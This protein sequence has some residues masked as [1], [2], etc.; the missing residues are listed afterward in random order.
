[1]KSLITVIIFSVLTSKIENVIAYSRCTVRRKI[2][3]ILSAESPSNYKDTSI[4]VKAIVGGL[5]SIANAIWGE[6]NKLSKRVNSKSTIA[7]NDILNGVVGDFE[8]GYLFSGAIDAELYD[9]DCSFTDPTISFTGLST[10]ERNIASL[11]PVL[12]SFVGSSVV[13]LYNCSLTDS[14]V[15][16]RWRMSG[17][18]K[19]PWNPRIELTGSTRLTF[20][21]TK[22]GRIVSYFETWD[23]PAS[24]ALFQLLQP[25]IPI[26]FEFD[27]NI[28]NAAVKTGPTVALNVASLKMFLSDSSF[29][30]G[31]NNSEF[32]NALRLLEISSSIS[33]IDNVGG[34]EDVASRVTSLLLGKIWRRRLGQQSPS[35][36][37]TSTESQED[38]QPP[39]IFTREQSCT[40]KYFIESVLSRSEANGMGWDLP[41]SQ[42]DP[43]DQR[44]IN[45]LVRNPHCANE[46]GT[47]GCNELW[48]VVYLDSDLL[49]AYQYKSAVSEQ[50]PILAV[51]TSESL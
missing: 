4:S 41:A 32:F 48:R 5:T 27:G 14:S 20:D 38:N 47:A 13:V 29:A 49:L 43:F 11:K 1:M 9:E 21:P 12:D 39:I 6:R 30:A 23:I 18:V 28:G 36:R 51:F 45:L 40:D 46:Q 50:E 7:P 2:T 15:V 33:L 42:Y 3:R 31:R 26:E 16:T 22:N 10:F 19:L 24:S 17:N 35:S 44:S 8:R 25:S 37:S 34:N